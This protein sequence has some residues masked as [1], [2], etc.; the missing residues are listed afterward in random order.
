MVFAAVPGNIGLGL[1]AQ[2]GM[3]RRRNV[4]VRLEAALADSGADGGP[5]IRRVA[6]EDPLHLPHRL[7]GDTQRRAPPSGVAGADGF[8]DGVVEQ[9]HIAVGGEHHQR[10][11]EHVG[12]HAVHGGIVPV[13]PQTLSCV[14]LRHVAH[15]ILVDLLGQHHTVHIC[16]QRG[17]KA[18]VVLLYAGDFIAPAYP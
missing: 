18:A 1:V 12:H 13:T 11:M 2:R 10:Q 4:A 15:H 14:G 3:E 5:D 8:A 9:H 7:G 17:A 16:A 6:A